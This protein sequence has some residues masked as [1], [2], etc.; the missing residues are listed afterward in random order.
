[1]QRYQAAIQR[2]GAA[3]VR[4][5]ARVCVLYFCFY[6]CAL[7]PHHRSVDVHP[8]HTI[9][10]THCVHL[11]STLGLISCARVRARVLDSQYSCAVELH[12]QQ[13]HWTVLHVPRTAG[14]LC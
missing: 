10:C 9:S 3:C 13:D 2:A 7:V 11:F 6:A 4:V 14:Y 12:C 5:R 8:Y 1:M